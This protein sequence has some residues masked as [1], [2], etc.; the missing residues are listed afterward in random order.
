MSAGSPIRS[1]ENPLLKRVAAVA[2][3]RDRERVL[4]EGERLVEDAIGAGWELELVLVSEDEAEMA[5]RLAGRVRELRLVEPRLLQRLS[6]LESPPGL[7]AL[8]PRPHGQRL[9]RLRPLRDALALVV[10]GLADPGNLGALARSAEAFG[11]LA[12]LRV[13]GSASPW[14]SKALRGSMG[15]LL[16]LPV[17]ECA[18]AGEAQETL[19]AE[20]F[21][22]RHAATRGG[23]PPAELDWSGRIALWIGGETGSRFEP[24]AGSEPVT[25]PM[26]PAVESLNVGVA[27]SQ[28]LYLAW[29]SRP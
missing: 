17:I 16:R 25:I 2:C 21:R 6:A 13:A 27:A 28:L 3:G 15:S 11:A 20:G 24:R 8:A 14:N 1:R 18:S 26:A 5:G 12:L 9:D 10:D 19:A 7:L 29:S 4:L 22:H 23:R